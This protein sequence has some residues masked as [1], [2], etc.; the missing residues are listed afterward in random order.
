MTELAIDVS[1]LRKEF[2]GKVAVERVDLQLPKGEVWGFVGPNGSGKTT[3]IRMLCGLLKP[4]AGE[5]TCLGLDILTQSERIKARAG[6][7]TQKFSFWTDLTVRENLE[8]V[9]RLHLL[10]DMETT[11]QR[12]IRGLG[13]EHRQNQLAGTL[14]GGW[15]Q[16]LALA[17]VTMH[18][19]ELLLLDEPTAGVDPLARRDFWDQI[20]RL[21][22]ESNVTTLVSTHYM[23]E[24]ERCD[25]VVYM[26]QGRLVI[27]G[28][29]QDIIA[30]S[31]LV[32][33]RAEGAG[34]RKLMSALEGKPGVE[35]VAY[36]GAA[37]HASGTERSV[38]EK[39]IRESGLPD[40]EWREVVPNLEDAF[41]ALTQQA[42]PVDRRF[43]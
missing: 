11:V 37:L 29:V 42:G 14:S 3:T 32:T 13:L 27:Q 34:V 21:G 25:R 8:F 24:A 31:G 12:T 1:G 16:R 10:D 38:I 40:V 26:A 22:G 36:F 19:P 7:M 9:A 39:T 35:H 41:I 23:D 43:A 15:Q 4:T 5:G 17:A 30:S 33:F 20:H 2:G 28:T 18:Q 6:Y